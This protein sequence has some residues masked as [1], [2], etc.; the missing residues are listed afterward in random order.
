[1]CRPAARSR[2]AVVDTR[3][4]CLADVA[5]LR[6]EPGVFELV[7]SDSTV[8]RT[9]DALAA[10]SQRALAAISAARSQARARVWPR[11]GEHLPDHGLC[12]DRPV[13]IDVD[14]TLITAHSDKEQAAPTFKRGF[15]FHP[16]WTFADHGAEG[17]GESLSFLPRKGN[18]RLQY[19]RRSSPTSRCSGCQ[20]AV[21]QLP[22]RDRMCAVLVR[23]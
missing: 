17:T 10:D 8:S 20:A 1:M 11:A 5:L 12:S 7:T 22:G 13:V 15:G 3:V 18:A 2:I 16:L 4:D 14:A 21:R 9:V 19:H 6:E 23:A